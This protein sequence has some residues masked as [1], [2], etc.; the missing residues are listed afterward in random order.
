MNQYVISF[1]RDGVF[2]PDG[3]YTWMQMENANGDNFPFMQR[4]GHMKPGD[5]LR[6]GGGSQPLIEIRCEVAQ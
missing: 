3:T 4:L 2:V 1:K 6:D 5:V